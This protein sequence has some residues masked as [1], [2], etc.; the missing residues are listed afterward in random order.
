MNS[1]GPGALVTEVAEELRT[2]KKRQPVLY[3][4]SIEV[5]MGTDTDNGNNV[6]VSPR[7]SALQSSFVNRQFPAPHRLVLAKQ[8]AQT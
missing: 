7:F 8:Q 5:E 1:G 6:G 2:A 3:D 4:S